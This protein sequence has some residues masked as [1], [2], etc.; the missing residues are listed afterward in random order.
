CC[1]APYQTSRSPRTNFSDAGTS[2]GWS[3]Q[4]TAG[5][6]L[7]RKTAAMKTVAITGERPGAVAERPDPEPVGEL[8]VVKILVAPMCTEY[9]AYR[10][11]HLTTHLGHEAAGEVVEVEQAGRVRV[12]DRVVVM[13]QYPCGNCPLCLCGEYIHCQS[14]LDVP[15]LTGS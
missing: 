7:R 15:A 5:P 4:R 3:M 1:S 10:D 9:K 14:N 13:P 6:H 8:V 11:G 12:G 2:L